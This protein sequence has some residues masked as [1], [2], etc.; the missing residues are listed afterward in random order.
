MSSE[1]SRRLDGKVALV[2]GSGGGIGK[3]YALL[4]ARHGARVVV[5]DIGLRAGA[6]AEAVA[7]EIRAAGGEA[8]ASTQSAT[9]DGAE[10]LVA[11]AGDAYGQLDILINNATF[12]R[13]GDLWDYPE[14]D[15]DST[16]AVNLKG[17]F[18][19]IRYAAPR[20]AA[21]GGGVIVNVSSASG[22]G[23]ASHTA[24]GTAKE[25]VIGLTR[26]VARELGH[27]GI[28][29]NAV[30]PMAA[31]QSAG[32]F[33]KRAARWSPLVKGTMSPRIYALQQ[34]LLHTPERLSTDK[35][36]PLVAWLCTDAAGNVNG[37][38]F[39]LHGDTVTRLS[40]PEPVRSISHEG[41]WDLDLLDRWAPENLVDGL[42]NRFLLE[43]I[44]GLPSITR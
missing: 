36:A 2:T 35:A 43:G 44:E 26:S 34:Q 20:L 30:R 9:W 29:C 18:A 37:Q 5:N 21:Q 1:P 23:H 14:E 4:L 28:R 12:T 40:E 7:K 16:L 22:L 3:Q 25:G 38:T 6:S 32:E 31:G 13:L 41:G 39:E 19:M 17:Y 42:Q 8:V 10:E 24:Y 33:V 11:T 15:W 27:F